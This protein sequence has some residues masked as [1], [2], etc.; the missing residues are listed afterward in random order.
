M[1][2]EHSQ[3]VNQ[4]NFHFLLNIQTL[5]TRNLE[6]VTQINEKCKN[7][8]SKSLHVIC[9]MK[10]VLYLFIIIVMV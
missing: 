2:R 1:I 7:N 6:H 5:A 9:S 4:Q 3:I 8:L 10:K